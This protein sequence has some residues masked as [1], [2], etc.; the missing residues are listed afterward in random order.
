M[1]WTNLPT[2]YTNA[3]WSGNRKFRQTNNTDGTVSFE[4]R[5]VYTTRENSFFGA[6]DANN[7]NAAI[8]TLMTGGVFLQAKGRNAENPVTTTGNLMPMKSAEFSSGDGMVVESDGVKVLESGLYRVQASISLR[9]GDATQRCSLGISKGQTFASA[10]N[11]IYATRYPGNTQSQEYA[12]SAKIVSLNANDIVFM[13]ATSRGTAGTAD[14]TS[15]SSFLLVE[16][17]S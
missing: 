1:A 2:N 7:M 13:T 15:A 12:T 17:I 9:A 16:K 4:D 6:N 10:T 5:T 8:N 3:S 14:L 11:V